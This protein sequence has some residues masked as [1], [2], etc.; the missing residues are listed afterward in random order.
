MGE[1]EGDLNPFIFCCPA[2]L[3]DLIEMVVGRNKDSQGIG[4]TFY[5]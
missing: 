2:K 5:S 4:H 1:K 3:D